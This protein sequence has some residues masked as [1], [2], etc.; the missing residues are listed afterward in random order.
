MAD[1]GW[2][3]ARSGM[4][5]IFCLSAIRHPPS[6]ISLRPQ[7]SKQVTWF[8]DSPLLALHRQRDSG[9]A[10]FGVRDVVG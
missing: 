6:A 2:V 10:R 4:L 5:L 1:S 9:M 8:Y 7:D 3:I